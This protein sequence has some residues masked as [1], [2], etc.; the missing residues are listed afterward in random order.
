MIKQSGADILRMWVCASDYA[1]DLRIG[2][3]ILKTT[4]ETYRKLR[5]TIRWM[6]GSLA[7]FRD[8]DRV[9]PATMPELE[10]LMLHRLAELDALV[11]QAYADF[12]YK[13]IFAALNAFMTADLSAFYFDIRKDALYCD[14]ISSTT[15]KACLTVLDHLFRATVTWLAP[16]LPF[17]AEEAWLARYPSEDGSVH[18][19]QFPG[20]ARRLARRGAR[21]EM[22]QGAQRPPRGHRRARDRAGAKAHRLLARGR[23]RRLRVRPRPVRGAGRYRPGGGRDHLGRDPGRRAMVR[24]PRS[25]STT[26]RRWRS[27]CGSREGTKCARSWKILPSVGSDPAYPDVIAARRPGAAGMGRACARRRNDRCDRTHTRK[28]AV[29]ARTLLWGPLTRFGLAVALVAAAIDQAAKLWLL[30]VF[31]L[32]ARGIVT[33]TPFLDLVL[34]WNTGISYGLFRQDGPLGQW[35]LLALKAAAVVLLWIW[36]ART[37]SRLTALSLGLIIGG[38]IGNAIDRLAYG[39]VADFVLFH[40]TTASFSFK[41]YVFNLADVAIVAGVI[42]LLYETLVGADAAKAP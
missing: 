24:R 34:A 23:T 2:P 39:A 1:D 32:G 11:R 21:G 16:M 7:H 25:A 18:L 20:R 36:L 4:V 30:F 28:D 22:A 41:W 8:E 15:R 35:V 5:N 38:A 42:G 12:D 27:R 14:P 29:G 13:R 26:S 37:S 9:A 6:L 19:E 40:V 3:E 17:T 33:L 10:R 31:D